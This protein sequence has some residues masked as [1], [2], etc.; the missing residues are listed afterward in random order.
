MPLRMPTTATAAAVQGKEEDASI[1]TQMVEELRRQN[2]RMAAL[3]E[4]LEQERL[5]IEKEAKE[6]VQPP[7]TPQEQGLR[8]EGKAEDNGPQ[9]DSSQPGHEAN[10]GQEWPQEAWR[11]WPQETRRLRQEKAWWLWS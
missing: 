10:G 11:I 2:T 8:R 5:Q 6:N 1:L 7:A 9:K 4:K 3:E